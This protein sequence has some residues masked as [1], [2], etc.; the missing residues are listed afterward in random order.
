ML[1][2]LSPAKNLDLSPVSLGAP[3]TQPALMKDAESLMRT[4]RGLTQTKIRELMGLSKDLAKLN[5][6]RYRAFEVPFTDDNALPAALM[7]NG[8]VYRGLGARDL[9]EADLAWAQDHLAI[10][11]GLYGVLRPLDLMQA[12]RLEMGTRLKTRRG[13]NLYHFW[14]ARVAKRLEETLAAHE[15]DTLVNLA[16]N[17]YFKAVDRKAFRPPIVECV[18]EDWKEHPDEGK[19]IS[20]MAKVARGRMARY[21]I[22]ERVDRVE[23]LKD[24]AVDRYRYAPSASTEARR[25]FRREFVPGTAAATGT[26]K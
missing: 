13:K 22:T 9:T 1:A 20:F 3:T 16:S 6:D 10:L 8:D 5:Y 2:V 23:G 7:F 12:Y 18:F 19:V 26:R 14:G 21:L 15:D 24:F 25:V 17:E 11:S 4:T